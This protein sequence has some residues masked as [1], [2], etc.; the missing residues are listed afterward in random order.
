MDGW[1][2]EH[3]KKVQK[4]ED[5]S[6]HNISDLSLDIDARITRIKQGQ[7]SKGR[8]LIYLSDN[9]QL[10]MDGSPSYNYEYKPSS[11]HDFLQEGHAIYKKKGDDTL[12][13]KTAAGQNYYFVF[14]R[15]LNK[16][17]R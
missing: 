5:D 13:I 7:A 9:K 16:D 12:H 4:Q 8:I 3:N 1:E 14:G 15:N 2:E 17:K 11:L 6:Y 10:R